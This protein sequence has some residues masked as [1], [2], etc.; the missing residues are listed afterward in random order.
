[1]GGDGV[2]GVS[3]G[4]GKQALYRGDMQIDYQSMVRFRVFLFVAE[5]I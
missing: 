1:M 5:S 2:V 3:E 4:K